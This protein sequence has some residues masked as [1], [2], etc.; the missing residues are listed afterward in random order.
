MQ[1]NFLNQLMQMYGI[2]KMEP[3]V[4][5]LM[6]YQQQFQQQTQQPQQKFNPQQPF[7]AQQPQVNTNVPQRPV[8][9]FGP[10]GQPVAPTTNTLSPQ[11]HFQTI[12]P[13]FNMPDFGNKASTG[14]EVFKP[15]GKFY[16]PNVPMYAA[17]NRG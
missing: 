7:V 2:N 12:S 5:P 13:N 6:Q 14:Q 15:G 17:P 1:Y 8:S 9:P 4:N 3:T 11:G 16:D 10:Q